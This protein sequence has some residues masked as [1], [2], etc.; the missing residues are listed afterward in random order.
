MCD[1][2]FYRSF[3]KRN[4]L[5]RTFVFLFAVL[6]S[7]SIFAQAPQGVGYQGVAA[8][9]EGLELSNQSISIRASI[10]SGS[11][12]GPI[13]WQEA[14][15]TVTDDYGLFSINIGEGL[16]TGAGALSDFSEVSW[17]E[18]SHFLQIE[19]DATGGDDYT[20]TSTSQMMSVPYA[21]Y[22]ERTNFDSIASVLLEDADFVN[23]ISKGLG[24]GPCDLIYPDGLDGEFFSHDLST[25][26]TVPNNQT[27]YITN[28]FVSYAGISGFDVFIDEILVHKGVSGNASG[29]SNNPF[30]LRSGQ[31]IS[32]SV[33]TENNAAGF[34]GFLV[35]D[36]V[37]PITEDLFENFQVPEGKKLVVT[38]LFLEDNKGFY[39]DEVRLHYDVSN[40]SAVSKGSATPFVAGP[41]QV[42]SS[43]TGSYGSASVNGYLVDLDFFEDC[44]QTQGP[45]VTN[46]NPSSLIYTIDGF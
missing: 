23:D 7:T 44:G 27:L 1:F 10:L 15:E 22:A 31:T 37:E 18:S 40:G 20:L 34:N 16:S 28:L 32:A 2:Q 35:S 14:H 25:D 8:D 36:G 41:G 43:T 30:L 38:N 6:L 12:T 39:I 42:L 45:T 33:G 5:M 17:G 26:F 46:S 9:S 4:Y 13:Q 19:M 21:L 29:S 11:A 24:I 3:L